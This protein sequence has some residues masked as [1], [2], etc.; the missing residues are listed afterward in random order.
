L[1]V[2]GTI[3]AGVRL[4]DVV[5]PPYDVI[6]PVQ[7][8]ELYRRDPHNVVRL[9]LGREPDRY[10]EAATHLN[11]WR[12]AGIL[13]RDSVPGFYVLA[14]T[15]RGGDG[16]SHQRSGVI[17]AV[18][19]VEF[20]KGVDPAARENLVQ[21]EGRPFPLMQATSDESSGQI[22]GLVSDPEPAGDALLKEVMGRAPSDGGRIRRGAES[23]MG[24]DRSG[25]DRFALSGIMRTKSA[26]IADGHIGT[27]P[28][29]RTV[30]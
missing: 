4:A 10:R 11:S 6:S 15:F 30:T 9:I 22:F 21:A 27:K 18:R 2:S 20:G 3:S 25:D 12:A 19:L 24:C 28:L 26:L 5:A 8:E 29:L 17:T 7:Q 16:V 13:R 14:Q 1:P 23:A